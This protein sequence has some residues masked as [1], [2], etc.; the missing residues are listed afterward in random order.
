[1]CARAPVW[2]HFCQDSER[3]SHRFA[4]TFQATERAHGGQHMGGISPVPPTGE[5][6]AARSKLLQQE[7]EQT[8]LSPMSQQATP[9]C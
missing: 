9:K 1:M 3:L 2:S 8:A 6:P 5:D 7:V 4:H